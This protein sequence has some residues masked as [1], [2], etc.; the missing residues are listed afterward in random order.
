MNRRHLAVCA[1]LCAVLGLTACEDGRKSPGKVTVR[2]V[3]AA[4]SL[5]LVAYS[6][7]RP[8]TEE[9]TPLQYKVVTEAVYDADTYDFYAYERTLSE[10]YTPRTWTFAR[11]LKADR[12]YTFVLAEAA[13]EVQPLVVEYSEAPATEAQIAAV[14]A[15]PGLPAMDLY[16]ERPGI[17]I[18]GATPRGTF[19]ALEQI[20][21]RTLA[22]G[23]YEVW[24]T[25]AGNP[26]NVLMTSSTVNLP[27]GLTTTLVVIPEP[28][29][30]ATALSVM[31]VQPGASVLY[32]RNSTALLRV[33]N[34]ANDAAPRDF[35][36]D[37]Q[38]SPPL[39]SA[40]PFGEPTAFTTI[41]VGQH[42]INVTPV[43]N[44][45]VLELDQQFTGLVVQRM[46]LLFT[47]DAGT[48]SYTAAADD[49]RRIAN[50]AK[51]LFLN[52]ATQF[53]GVDFLVLP[54]DA[55]PTDAFAYVS[56]PAP[57]APATYGE[58]APGDYDLY[59]RQAGT[60]TLL[61]GPTQISVASEGI[62]G[63]LAI[64]GAD[65]ATAGVVLFDDFVP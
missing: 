43:G 40:I 6:R 16:L 64:N 56:L 20:A 62:Y 44:P 42:T 2:V 29:I 35:A 60:T 10:S 24:L 36:I 8:R 52:V 3:N 58:V 63:V 1:L 48:L 61:S 26:A 4:P 15:A 39:F 19:N 33:V 53:P 45:G 49:G 9:P 23:D 27:A 22:S 21:P 51:I 57:G 34:G 30:S 47:G 54:R 14:H 32:D 5:A 59:L 55:N 37:S 17:G 31:A 50:E 12:A 7:E 13:G 38:F 41:P 11:E 18:A 65:T 25:A 28:G 46:T